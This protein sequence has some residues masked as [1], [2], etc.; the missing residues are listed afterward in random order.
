MFQRVRGGVEGYIW[1][2]SV[3]GAMICV[4]AWILMRAVGLQ[5]AEFWTFVIFIVGFIPC[6]A[7]RS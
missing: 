4:V 7:G 1:V 5:N 3:T 2:Q 6:W